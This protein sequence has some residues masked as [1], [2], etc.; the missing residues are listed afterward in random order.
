M[1]ARLVLEDGTEFAGVSIGAERSSA[2]EVVFNTAM[3]GYPESLTDPSYRGQILT[4]TYPLI[5]NYGV[6]AEKEDAFGFPEKFESDRIHVAGVVLQEHTNYNHWNARKSF[7][8]WLKEHNI[9]G[10]A[11]VDT[12][13]LT[14]KLREHG[15]MLGKI[16]IEEDIEF[17]DP[18]TRNLVAEVS[19]KEKQ[20]FGKG[21]IT[22][23]VVDCG[24]KYS[25]VRNFLQR[26]VKV[27]YVPWDYDFTQEEFDGLFISNGPGDPQMADVT[28]ENIKKVMHE[29][30]TFGI[31]LGNQLLAL[32][33]GAQTYKLQYGHRSH[34]QPCVDK[35]TGRCYITSQNHGFAVKT[36]TLPDEFV[37]WFVNAN[38]DTNEGIKHRTKP[39]FSVQFHPESKGGPEDTGYLFDEFLTIVREHKC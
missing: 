9:P 2:G 12:R 32:A 10:I 11:G 28:I 37:P 20:E 19:I 22:I 31:C 18:N 29:K 21:D 13:A 16:I 7:G 23:C 36:E 5:G 38:D 34:N 26:G 1:N 35:E 15:V 4:F 3:V 24:C 8:E 6:Q 33:A 39:I 27:L 30:P 25:I 14:K 17:D